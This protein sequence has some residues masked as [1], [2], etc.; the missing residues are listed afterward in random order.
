[1]AQ[2]LADIPQRLQIR[3]YAA[4]STMRLPRQMALKTAP[5]IRRTRERHMSEMGEVPVSGVNQANLWLPA[6]RGV[7]QLWLKTG[8]RANDRAKQTV[9][10]RGIK[11][12][13][14]PPRA[15][16][17]VD[18]GS[19]PRKQAFGPQWATS[20]RLPGSGLAP[21]MGDVGGV[22]RARGPWARW[23][24]AACPRSRLRGGAGVRGDERWDGV[25][26][27]IDGERSSRRSTAAPASC[28]GRSRS[29]RS[30]R[31]RRSGVC[32]WRSSSGTRTRARTSS[33]SGASRRCLAEQVA[34]R[35]TSA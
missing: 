14:R 23:Q 19:E 21:G 33:G 34:W 18:V 31:Q 35:Q 12:D 6:R 26:A 22:G 15:G 5:G 28:S 16:K 30:R 27:S 8:A 9:G 3:L 10:A 7:A 25:S 17:L 13:S 11:K 29:S 20:G 32:R 2:I 24:P 1:M 4:H